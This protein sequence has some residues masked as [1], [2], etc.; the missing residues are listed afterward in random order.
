MAIVQVPVNNTGP[1]G[2]ASTWLVV[3]T[4]VPFWVLSIIRQLVFQGPKRGP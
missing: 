4:M 2:S 3:K 1:F